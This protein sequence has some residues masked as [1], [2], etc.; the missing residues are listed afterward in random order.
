MR[1]VFDTNVLISAFITRGASHEVF[2]H[3]LLSHDVFVSDYILSEVETVLRDKFSFPARE[4]NGI[5][6]YLKKHLVSI[7]VSK[8][9]EPICR[10]RE[11]DSILACAQSAEADCLI[12]GD[13]DL[14]VLREFKD[15]R[16]IRPA[17]FWK[18]EKQQLL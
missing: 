15:A 6:V 1:I 9:V 7:G 16:I 11:D 17:D 10:D 3:C 18:F 12:T 8:L 14:L 13:E 2:E 4:I 5:L